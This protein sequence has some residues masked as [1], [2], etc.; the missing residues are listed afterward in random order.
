MLLSTYT[1]V[2]HEDVSCMGVETGAYYSDNDQV[3]NDDGICPLRKGVNHVIVVDNAK[4]SV[5][6]EIET[7]LLFLLWNKITHL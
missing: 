4:I 7:C 2:P 1:C 5:S 6:A 3:D